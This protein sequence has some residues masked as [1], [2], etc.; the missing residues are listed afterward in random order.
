MKKE[1]FGLDSRSKSVTKSISTSSH[2]MRSLDDLNDR[3]VFED[4]P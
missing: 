1:S 3:E 4:E 2:E